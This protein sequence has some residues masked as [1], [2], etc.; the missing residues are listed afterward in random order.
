MPDAFAYYLYA[1]DLPELV[2]ATAA[3]QAKLRVDGHAALADRVVKA[4]AELERDLEYLAASVSG[5]GTVKLVETERATK[6][7]PDTLG[8]GGPRLEDSL[9]C[10]PIPEFPGSVGVANEAVLDAHVPWWETNEIG[11]SARVGGHIFGTFYESG[12]GGGSPPGGNFRE[13][14]LFRAEVGG[15]AGPGVIHRPIPERRFIEQSIPD[16]RAAWKSGFAAIKAKYNAQLDSVFASLAAEE[17]TRGL[18]SA[19]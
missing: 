11:S 18:E 14:A 15:S 12:G 2:A 9:V 19:R 10:D 13:H 17:V 3:A 5:A 8:A 4:Y 7:R 1:R 16:I 6:V